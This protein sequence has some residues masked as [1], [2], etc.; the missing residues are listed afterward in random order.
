MYSHRVSY[1]GPVRRWWTMDYGTVVGIG[2]H[3]HH[4]KSYTIQLTTSS[5]CITHKRHHIKPTAVTVDTYIQYHSTKQQNTRTDPLA[6]ILNNIIKNPAAYVTRQ[7]TNDSEQSNT[8]QKEEAKDSEHCS[9]EASNITKQLCT[10][11]AKDNRTIIKYGDT[12]R[13]RSGHISKKLDRLE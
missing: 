7:T 8:K 2:N 5:R 3:N 4:N 1:S 13:T 10:Q 12:I 11:A 9:M 6:E